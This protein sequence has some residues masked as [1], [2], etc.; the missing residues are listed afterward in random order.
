MANQCFRPLTEFLTSIRYLHIVPQ[1]M[2]DLQHSAGRRNDPF[3]G[4]F[5]ETIAT[6]PQ[7][8]R[9]ARLRKISTALKIAIP[10][11]EDLT[12]EQDGG[13]ALAFASSL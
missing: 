10:Q 6:T 4:N 8:T 13:G 5:L 9:D 1:L 12:L 3:G 2:R 11:L 7:R